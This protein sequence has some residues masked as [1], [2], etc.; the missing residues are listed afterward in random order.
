MSLPVESN[1]DFQSQAKIENL[2]DPTSDQ[3]AATKAYA[4]DRAKR[5]I[6]IRI[7]NP[8]V[9][10]A[11]YRRIPRDCTIVSA[12]VYASA[13]CSAVIDVWAGAITTD[14]LTDLT[15]ADTITAAAKPTL[16]SATYSTDATLTGWTTGLTADWWMAWNVDSVSGDPEWIELELELA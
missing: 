2:P 13:S 9:G 11:A 4:D 16:S 12:T 6:T 7:N 3:E 1:L 8:E 5:P 14:H 15:V 10:V